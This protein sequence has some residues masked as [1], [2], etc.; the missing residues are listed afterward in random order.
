MLLGSMNSLAPVSGFHSEMDRLFDRMVGQLFRQG[1]EIGTLPLNVWETDEAFLCEAEVP[2]VR[3][4]DLDIQVNGGELT[5]R[6]RWP[7]VPQAETWYRQERPTGEFQR[8]V[9]LP[10][11]VKPDSVDAALHDGVLQIRLVKEDSH[12]P[13]RIEVKH[14][15]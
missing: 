10:P 11:G 1:N 5:V 14:V 13:R 2:G 3:M 4:E 9:Q 7:N 12:R 15:A 8:I 6:G